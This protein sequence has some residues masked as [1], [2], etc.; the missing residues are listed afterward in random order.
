MKKIKK[1][2]ALA[3]EKLTDQL[4]ISK[5]FKGKTIFIPGNHD[6]YSGITGLKRQQ[7]IVTQYLDFKKSFTGFDVT[8]VVDGWNFIP[9]F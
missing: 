7:K 8:I 2:Y 3:H 4:A 9:I 1:A 5:N 6:W